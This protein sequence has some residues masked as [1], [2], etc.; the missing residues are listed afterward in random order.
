MFVPRTPKPTIS[1]WDTAEHQGTASTLSPELAVKFMRAGELL[2]GDLAL[3]TDE[4]LSAVVNACP[5]RVADAVI[6]GA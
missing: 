1:S 2:D 6:R 4:A 3:L 5:E